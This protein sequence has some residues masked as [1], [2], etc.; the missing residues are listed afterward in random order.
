MGT[1]P[2]SAGRSGPIRLDVEDRASLRAALHRG[3]VVV[4][5]VGPFQSRTTALLEAACEIGT[6]VIDLNE[7]LVHARRVEAFADRVRA[8]GISV[9]ST[10]SAVSTVAAALVRRSGIDQ[11]VRVSA[12]VAP[13]SRETAHP[14]TIG[15]LLTSIGR[16]VE[17]WRD[18]HMSSAAGWRETRAFAL[19][20]RR[21]YLVASALPLTL[22]PVWSSLR[23][24]D[25]WTDTSTPLSN[26]LLAVAARAPLL[27][28]VAR[29][30]VPLGAALARMLGTHHGAFAIEVEDETGRVARLALTAPR[31]SYLIA[32]AP[33]ALAAR[34]LAEGRSNETGIVPVDRHV[35]TDELFA[36]LMSLGIALEVE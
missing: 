32:A 22:P 19:P 12:L 23:A 18:G 15:A 6:D 8:T 11:P 16:P 26:G 3:D 34:E 7:S 20:R 33:A 13:A 10:C 14:G 27:Q 5:A 36:Y 30:A 28:T 24:V 35:D 29:R 9:R 21:A 1:E 31:R 25:C 17:V 4:D 2:V